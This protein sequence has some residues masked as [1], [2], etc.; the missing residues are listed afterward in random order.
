MLRARLE[1]LVKR[2]IR[3]RMLAGR[4]DSTTFE[5]QPA[6]TPQTPA[7][8]VLM[9]L[10]NRPGRLGDVL[11]MLDAQTGTPGG[12]E[13]YLWNNNK[14]DHEH[15]LGVLR[16]ATASGALQRVHIVRTPYN[17]GSMA[18]WYQARAIARIQGPGPVIVIDD[19]ENLEPGFVATALAHY[20]PKSIH[21]WWA[22]QVKGAY[23]DRVEAA[24]GDPID[25]VGP[26]GS[27]T[28]SSLFLDDRFFTTMPE[29]FWMLDDLWLTWYAKKAGW[30]L[31]KLPVHIEFVLHETNQYHAQ[32]DL[33]Q[34]FFEY[35]YGAPGESL[36]TNTP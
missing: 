20:A 4:F 10:W 21:A 29:R 26:G 17:L 12:V 9:C 2:L 28:D 6:A 27:V 8:P 33:K 18:R 16:A 15:Y 11:E 32:I 1:P 7:Q 31:E 3:R 5:L 19:D 22:W 14:L 25:H 34:E 30:S 35:L 36:T 24:E 13:L 23:F